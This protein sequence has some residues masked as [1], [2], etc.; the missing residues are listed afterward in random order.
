LAVREIFLHYV[1]YH[2]KLNISSFCID[3]YVLGDSPSVRFRFRP[4]LRYGLTPRGAM[5][6]ILVAGCCLLFWLF[7]CYNTIKL[8]TTYL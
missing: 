2:Y 8:S 1:N 4:P 7:A 3:N 6:T 5:I